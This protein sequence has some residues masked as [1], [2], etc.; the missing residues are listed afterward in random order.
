M[1]VINSNKANVSCNKP[2]SLTNISPLITISKA[3]EN[4]L[5]KN[6]LS[7]SYAFIK[8]D[9]PWCNTKTIYKTKADIP[10]ARGN[11]GH[12]ACPCCQSPWLFYEY[13]EL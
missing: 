13:E 1:K 10:I 11:K 3:I 6:N 12:L 7:L 8:L 9:C 4:L 2:I 5:I